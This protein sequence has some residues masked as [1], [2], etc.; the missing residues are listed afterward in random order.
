MLDGLRQNAGSWVIKILFGVIILAF[1]FAYGSGTLGGKGGGVL[2]YLGETPIMITDFQSRLRREL[3]AVRT[4]MPGLS[5][6]D[7]SQMRIKD[8]V[9]ANMVNSTLIRQQALEL[10]LAVSDAELQK[11]IV[12]YQVFRGKDGRFDTGIYRAVLRGSNMTPA[13]FET[14]M[15]QD[16]MAEKLQKYL[17]MTVVVD[18]A[19]VRDFFQYG[20]ERVAIDYLLF[21]WE[22]FAAEVQSS[23]EQVEKYYADNQDRF[24]RPARATLQYLQFTPQALSGV[25]TV[26]AEEIKTYYDTH[27][28]EFARPEQV[29]ARHILLK[30]DA[31]APEA[32]VKD[33]RT[34]LLRLKARLAKGSTFEELA[35]K[36]SE[37]PSNATGGDLGWFSRGMMVGPFEEA[38]F[39]LKPGEVSEPIR[40]KFGWHLL[41]LEDHRDE[42]VKALAEAESDIRSSL[43]E[44]KAADALSDKLDQA[45]GQIIVGDT[46]VKVAEGLGMTLESTG[47]MTKDMLVQRLGIDAESVQL[48][49]DLETGKASETPLSIEGGYLLAAKSKFVESTVAPLDEVK[50]V[51]V[52][53][54]RREGALTLAQEKADSV[55]T[56]LVDP[57][58]AKAALVQYKA[59]LATSKP[60]ARRGLIPELGMNPEL[61]EAAFAGTEGQWLDKSYSVGSGYALARLVER[62]APPEE[63]WER[64]K[65]LL[66]TQIQQAKTNEMFMAYLSGLR[67]KIELKVVQPQLLEN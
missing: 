4:Q 22:D 65:E 7:I 21:P 26:S 47:A 40:T 9:L 23:D 42:G 1:V 17:D 14:G 50:G 41:K 58:K 34:K 27:Q 60:F 13:D 57:A 63:L 37:G 51:I 32:E 3:D 33:V 12:S 55:L 30:L 6:E 8:R 66:R 15:R 35:K 48:L 46:L 28:D 29:R 2:A 18:D 16:I 38:A 5:N 24:R 49:F 54:L 52:E 11:R 20:G 67:D 44:D 19:E 39:S 64:Q 56:E 31:G 36:Y 62:V 61:V 59:K 10:G 25:Q 45:I 53:T 43:A